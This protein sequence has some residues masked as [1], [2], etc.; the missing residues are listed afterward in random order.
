MRCTI[1]RVWLIPPNFQSNS[2]NNYLHNKNHL[3]RKQNNRTL[4]T[5]CRLDYI[6][7]YSLI[8]PNMIIIYKV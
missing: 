8:N 7:R 5:M 4:N 1:A 6:I 2:L 3:K